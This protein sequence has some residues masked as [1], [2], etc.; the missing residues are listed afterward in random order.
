MPCTFQNLLFIPK[1]ETKKVLW[2]YSNLMTRRREESTRTNIELLARPT[3]HY[4]ELCRNLASSLPSSASPYSSSWKQ[5]GLRRHVT[6]FA[7][8]EEDKPRYVLDRQ[9]STADI[10]FPPTFN[11][12]KREKY[13]RMWLRP[14]LTSMHHMTSN[15]IIHPK[16]ILLKILIIFTLGL[17]TNQVTIMGMY[18]PPSQSIRFQCSAHNCCAD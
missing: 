2:G 17:S 11:I 5:H 14:I 13:C 7:P 15:F 10:C 3:A 9:L 1:L 6:D 18:Y 8:F 4:W 16:I 12:A